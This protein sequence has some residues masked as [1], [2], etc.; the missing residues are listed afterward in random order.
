M[1]SLSA[2]MSEDRFWL[3]FVQCLACKQVVFRETMPIS[4][5]CEMGKEEA[6]THRYLHHYPAFARVGQVVYAHLGM[7]PGDAPEQCS[8]SALRSSSLAP[9]EICDQGLCIEESMEE[10]RELGPDITMLIENALEVA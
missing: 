3:T 5:K 8:M 4:H 6:D 10:E 2:G 1:E 7:S 9:T